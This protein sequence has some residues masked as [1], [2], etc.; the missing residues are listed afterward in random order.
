[1]LDKLRRKKG[2]DMKLWR[3]LSGLIQFL[4]TQDNNLTILTQSYFET[5]IISSK[6][7]M[8]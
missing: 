2:D 5:H 8:F 6:I 4:L 7:L 1:M 3:C